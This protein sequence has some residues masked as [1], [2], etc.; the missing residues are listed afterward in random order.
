MNTLFVLCETGVEEREEV[1][2]S[3]V[4]WPCLCAVVGLFVFT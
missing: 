4:V 1:F 3:A 2:T